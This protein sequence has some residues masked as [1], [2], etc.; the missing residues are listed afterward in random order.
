M[1]TK[2]LAP[3][4]AYFINR[5]T[6][7]G[8]EMHLLYQH[9][10]HAGPTPRAELSQRFIPQSVRE[11]AGHADTLNSALDA[12]CTLGLAQEAETQDGNTA[13]TAMSLQEERPFPISVLYG[14]AVAGER[15]KAL[16]DLYEWCIRADIPSVRDND[17]LNSARTH[18]QSDAGWTAEKI[19]FWMALCS[20]IGII[21]P[22]KG[23]GLIAP[24]AN[25]LYSLLCERVGHNQWVADVFADIDEHCVPCLTRDGILHSGWAATLDELQ[26]RSVVRLDSG[27][28]A[29][30]ILYATLSNGTEWS[31]LT[32]RDSGRRREGSFL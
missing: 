13:F 30:R 20:Y 1:S 8:P 26:Q 14:L 7:R 27:S 12:L 18:V 2:T 10:L 28:D 11:R 19:R 22:H 16:L 9:L 24:T 5:I 15:Q 3:S 23:G 21:L 6:L 4:N 25:V 17:L 29:P 32:L 31:R